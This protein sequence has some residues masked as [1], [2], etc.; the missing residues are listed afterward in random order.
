MNDASARRRRRGLF[1][2]LVLAAA[3]SAWLAQRAATPPAPEADAAAAAAVQ[4]DYVIETMDATVMD[5][6]GRPRY[7]LRAARLTHYPDKGAELEWPSLVQY[8]QGAPV[9]TR[10]RRGFLPDD[11]RSIRMQGDVV[12]SRGGGGPGQPGAE[13]RA[14]EML[15]QLE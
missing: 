1:V 7:V 12:S 14:E 11:R 9:H 10:A 6:T 5:E 13:V 4:P 3:A 15:I 8:G 2:G